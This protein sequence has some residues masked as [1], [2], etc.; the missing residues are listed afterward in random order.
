VSLDP[1]IAPVLLD[2]AMGTEL[3][4]AGLPPGTLPEEWL[5][6]RPEAVGAI[7]AAYAAAGATVALTC[8]FNV[9]S[10]RL[11]AA[12]PEVAV[13]QLCREAVALVKH[14]APES[15]I[16]GAVGPLAVAVPRGAAPST[17]AMSRPFERPLQALAEAGAHLLWLESQYDWREARAAL[18]AAAGVGLPVAVTFTLV[19]RDGRLVAPDGTPGEALL[20]RAVAAQAVAVGVN[21]VE[22]GPALTRLAGWARRTLPVPFIARASA[23]LP[24]ALRTPARFAEEL[25]PAVTA[26]AGLVGGCCGAGPAHVA[27]LGSL[28]RGY[29]PSR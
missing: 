10:P 7:H 21:C 14:H 20:I 13:E 5:L 16:A 11:A 4:A 1:R 27:A 22:P 17:Q 8:T 2:G 19:V 28:L 12:L 6:E 24:G 15:R 3:L 29:E 26:G 25:L 23:G 18:A 9:A